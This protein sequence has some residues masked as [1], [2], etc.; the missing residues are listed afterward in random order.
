M[1][2]VADAGYGLS[3]A[4][5]FLHPWSPQKTSAAA[6]TVGRNVF[7]ATHNVT[8]QSSSVPSAPG[9]FAKDAS[10]ASASALHRSSDIRERSKGRLK[11]SNAPR[12][13]TT[14]R[15]LLIEM[16]ENRRTATATNFIGGALAAVRH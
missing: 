8:H 2:C 6:E 9:G 16:R 14:D 10:R 4:S 1:A 5:A 15:F 13:D 3:A 11:P 12:P 7:C